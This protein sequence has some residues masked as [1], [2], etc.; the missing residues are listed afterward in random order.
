[1]L[2]HPVVEAMS[3]QDNGNGSS[4]VKQA[5]YL[6]TQELVRLS[7]QD[8]NAI[9][10]EIHGV[11]GLAPEETPKL[12]ER[13]LADL[14][15][16]LN[17]ITMEPP[18]LKTAYDL[19]QNDDKSRSYVNDPNFRLRFL[20]CELFDAKKAAIRMIKYLDFVLED[21]GESALKRPIKIT[22]F[23]KKEMKILRSGFLQLL[24]YRDRTG[25]PILTWVGNMGF[26]YDL[27]LRVSYE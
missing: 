19:S 6:I 20:R 21:F 27:K 24:P 9:N 14:D 4:F 16:F 18:S 13:T 23:T 22:D 7:F 15:L 2:H 11:R 17:E 25:R 12:L 8:R 5:D 1:M 10:E 26:H 3:D